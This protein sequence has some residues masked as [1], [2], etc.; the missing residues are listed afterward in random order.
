MSDSGKKTIVVVWVL[1]ALVMAFITLCRSLNAA[2][3]DDTETQKRMLNDQVTG[4]ERSLISSGV[5]S[6]QIDAASAT[7]TY[8]R[9]KSGTGNVFIKRIN[10]NGTVTTI[11]KAYGKWA[12]RT[13][14]T[15]T[16][17]ND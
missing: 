7:N 4:R 5:Q 11:D 6:Y 10:V 9:F 15:Y 17:I 12:S 14:L 2:P 1:M 13:S 3:I 8:I 16:P